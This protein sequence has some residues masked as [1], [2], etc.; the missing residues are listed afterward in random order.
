MD[1]EG[2]ERLRV[3]QIANL[4]NFHSSKN[5]RNLKAGK[6]AGWA[7]SGSFASGL[8]IFAIVLLL[9]FAMSLSAATTVSV[10]NVSG[11]EHLPF[12]HSRP[13]GGIR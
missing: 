7:C 8:K 2:A 4:V 5:T 6:P 10:G 1:Q 11:N 3:Q 13:P 12:C 9:A